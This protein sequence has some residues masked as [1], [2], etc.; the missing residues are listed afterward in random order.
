MAPLALLSLV[1]F[2]LRSCAQ[3]AGKWIELPG[4]TCY[5]D[6]I[7][8]TVPH[9]NLP[10][11]FSTAHSKGYQVF[12]FDG[13]NAYFRTR[14]AVDCQDHAVYT[15]PKTLLF[16]QQGAGG[17]VPAPLSTTPA[18]L[19]TTAAPVATTMWVD[20]AW[21]KLE[22]SDCNILVALTVKNAE[23][24][25]CFRTAAAKG[26]E[27]FSIENGDASFGTRKSEECQGELVDA[28]QKTLF[29]FKVSTTPA[30]PTTTSPP[31]TPLAEVTLA[32][33]TFAAPEPDTE[34]VTSS[35]KPTSWIDV[36]NKA[37]DTSGGAADITA[38]QAALT[39]AS[40][41]SAVQAQ[42]DATAAKQQYSPLGPSLPVLTAALALFALG[43]WTWRS[44]R[45]RPR[46]DTL[47]QDSE[48]AGLE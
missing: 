35:A 41:V 47:E 19:S 2:A 26:Y 8:L 32:V 31:T 44:A 10:D 21:M 43:A 18:P 38:V 7:V 30:A 24:H 4:K 34:Y 1:L 29:V 20:P 25:D 16:V 22:G 48:R 23:I 12:T 33:T 14:T 3:S 15:A 28:P 17:Q 13:A 11:S 40:K 37:T 45:G 46:V 6:E 27:V 39:D 5:E 9:S 42:Y 36:I